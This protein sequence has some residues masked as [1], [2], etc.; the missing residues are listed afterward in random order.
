MKVLI[1]GSSSRLAKCLIEFQAEIRLSE[2]EIVIPRIR[3]PFGTEIPKEVLGSVDFVVNFCFSYTGYLEHDRNTN[4]RGV[5]FWAQQ[6]ARFPDKKFIQISTD[7]IRFNPDSAYS[8]IKSQVDIEISS[9]KNAY[10]F[11]IPTLIGENIPA[12]SRAIFNF[13]EYQ[14]IV[15]NKVYVPRGLATKKIFSYLQIETFWHQFKDF[16]ES[17][18]KETTSISHSTEERY[19]LTEIWKKHREIS[20]LGGKLMTVKEFGNLNPFLSLYNSYLNLGMP[21][22]KTIE[23]LKFLK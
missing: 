1:L 17:G 19:S 20:G 10:I 5:Y 9:I 2:I 18:K 8:K 23:S 11:R 7:S 22:C 4:I 6:I 14:H 15:I 21:N 16:V 13:L 12:P 3:I